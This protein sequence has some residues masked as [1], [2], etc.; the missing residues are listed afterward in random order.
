MAPAKEARI[1][2]D[3]SSKYNEPN[4]FKKKK[5]KSEICDLC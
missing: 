3:T 4:K 5:K 2:Q 1:Y